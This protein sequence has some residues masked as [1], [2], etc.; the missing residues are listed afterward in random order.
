[1][2]SIRTSRVRAVV[3]ALAA[4]LLAAVPVVGGAG[5]ASAAA[6]TNL[7]IYDKWHPLCLDGDIWSADRDPQTAL[8]WACN[9]ERQQQWTAILA[10]DDVWIIQ[11]QRS[12]KCL[13][14]DINTWG[15]NGGRVQLWSCNLAPQQ[16]WRITGSG[17]YKT[18]RAANGKCL[19]GDRWNLQPGAKVQLW[20]CNGSDQQAWHA[21]T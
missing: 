6:F 8:L 9:L 3:L 15:Q 5:S 16:Q 4:L 10:H 12:G 2:G 11:N 20:D 18:W 21:A 7:Q 14:A 17:Y 19:D 1:M 13:D